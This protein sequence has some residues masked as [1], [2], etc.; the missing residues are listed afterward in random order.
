M[1]TEDGIKITKED[2]LIVLILIVKF[3]SKKTSY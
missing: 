1:L 2:I 3:S